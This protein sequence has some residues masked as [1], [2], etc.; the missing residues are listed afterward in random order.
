LPQAA[1]SGSASAAARNAAILRVLKRK[2][3]N[4]SYIVRAICAPV[5][6]IEKFASHSNLCTANQRT[7]LVNL[8]TPP[9]EIKVI[10]VK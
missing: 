6:R 1:I 5:K 4:P 3:K 10:F 7:A 2:R 9:L 8:S